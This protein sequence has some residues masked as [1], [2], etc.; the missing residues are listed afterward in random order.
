MQPLFFFVLQNDLS[1]TVAVF[2]RTLDKYVGIFLDKN[3]EFE[4][5]FFL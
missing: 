3:M 5:F 2:S 1:G 4:F